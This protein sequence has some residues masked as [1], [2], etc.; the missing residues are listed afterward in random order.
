MKPEQLNW[1]D[2]K[3]TEHLKCSVTDISKFKKQL[4]ENFWLGLWQENTTNLK[5]AEIQKQ[6]LKKTGEKIWIWKH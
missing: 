6:K 3:W 2:K 5:Y 4:E 1:I